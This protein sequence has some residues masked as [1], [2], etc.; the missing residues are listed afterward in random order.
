MIQAAQTRDSPH[1]RILVL[2]AQAFALG[3]TI[4]WILIPASAIF[5][6]AYGS[7][8]LPVT[9]IG[10]GIAGVV[11]SAMLTVSLRRRP[12][13]SVATRVLGGLSVSLLVA[14]SVL[15]VAKAD[16]IAF[17]LLVLAPIVIPVG[18]LFVVGQAGELLDV[19]SLKALYARVV[20]GFALGF[21]TGG[22]AGPLLLAVVGA[23][24]NLL[25]AAAAAAGLFFA[26]VVMTRR[27][28]PVE[29]AKI[30]RPDVGSEPTTLRSLT[31]NRYVMLIIGFQMLSAVESQW[32]DFLV[33]SSAAR[34]YDTTNEL[35]RFLSQFSAIAYGADILFLLV[36]AGLLLRRFGLRY[37]LTANSVG[38]LT[39][40]GAIIVGTTIAGSGATLVFGFIVAARVADITLADGAARTSLS[41]AYQAVPTHLRPVAQAMT[42]G[43]AVP[44][45]IG[46]S[47]VVLLVVQ[48]AGA[49]DGLVL[50]ILVGAVVTAWLVVAIVVYRAYRA[51]LLAN[52]RGRT[53][54]PTEL[55]VDDTNLAAILRL[56]GSEDQRDVWLGLD[57]LTSAGHPELVSE[58]ARLVA[59]ERVS[60]RID[61]LERLATA[62]P[63]VAAEAARRGLDDPSSEMRAMSIRILGT[64][65]H[66]S[67]L[68]G[69]ETHWNDAA[70]DVKAALAFAL[71]RLGDNTA[72]SHVAR[73]IGR[74]ARSPTPAER[75]VAARMLSEV[76]PG[77]GSE[78]TPL[79]VLISDPD[80]EVVNAAL[81]AFRW[82]EDAA[83]VGDV[84]RALD[85]R[86]TAGAAVDALVRAGDAALDTVD[87]GLR[88]DQH[89]RHA[90]ELLVRAGRDIGGPG[91]IA[92][93][94]RH[95]HH[96]DREVGLAVM[97]S[98]AALGFSYVDPQAE[99]SDPDHGELGS[100]DALV[101]VDLERAT[102]AVRAVVELTSEPTAEALASA[103]RDE[104]DVIRERVLAAFS[105]RHDADEFGRVTFQLAQRDTQSHALALEWLDV[106]LTG[107]DRALVALIEPRLS[108]EERLGALLRTFP[109]VPC[110]PNQVLLD[111]VHDPDDR[112][113]R[114]WLRACAMY[115]TWTTA[116]GH[117]V[118][119]ML[120]AADV[121]VASSAGDESSIVLETLGDIRGGRV[122]R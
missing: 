43:L 115:T 27:S 92:V 36:L 89:A 74:L 110:D 21:V 61:A 73:E 94:L 19:R 35:A 96:R 23:A 49:I 12:L 48:S 50:P 105:L 93:L 29:L 114:P 91:A 7:D 101:R 2:S 58:L 30:E 10:A 41:A 57:I 119:T 103:L 98:L 87:D 117:G 37:G 53:L 100:I 47:G 59:D 24:E 65:G 25:V 15:S 64:M 82:T 121:L 55:T 46:A 85:H 118:E 86:R 67:D 66:G 51:N 99:S 72:R 71:T 106:T 95:V 31:R 14:W 33:L 108:D 122:D 113:R 109:L 32:L 40:I 6:E 28:Y 68:A 116:E 60:I 39:L 45:A 79:Q 88:D 9:Y 83:L 42:E 75:Q 3:L 102:Y 84:L 16:W 76:E 111:L 18:F 38:V 107:T 78:R 70:P 26:L 54:D 44:V 112:W 22:L 34:R 80:P 4:A 52:L 11:S 13:A 97:H 56:V 104:L 69:I 77:A 81:A 63:T 120:A 62:A 8:L 5:L 1:R 90:Q 20:A 17:A